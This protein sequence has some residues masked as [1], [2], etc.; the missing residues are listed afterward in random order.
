MIGISSIHR[1]YQHVSWLKSQVKL[2]HCIPTIP[3]YILHT[4]LQSWNISCDIKYHLL[5]SLIDVRRQRPTDVPWMVV[6]LHTTI[7]NWVKVTLFTI[8]SPLVLPVHQHLEVETNQLISRENQVLF[9]A[10]D[11]LNPNFM[12]SII[13]FCIFVCPK[14][15]TD[16][17]DFAVDFFLII[18]ELIFV[19]LEIANFCHI[20]H[21]AH[22]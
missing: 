13:I 7:I 14:K 16:Q 4:V 8:F 18:F 5:W 22:L 9:T 20:E 19:Y 17:S 15:S 2:L 12:V 3:M 1:I 21:C 11:L 6:R 10:L